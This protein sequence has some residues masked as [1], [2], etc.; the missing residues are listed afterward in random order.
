MSPRLRALIERLRARAGVTA[1]AGAVALTLAGGAVALAPAASAAP[2]TPAAVAVTAARASAAVTGVSSSGTIWLGMQAVTVTLRVASKYSGTPRACVHN[3]GPHAI[4]VAVLQVNG[5]TDEGRL[6]RAGGSQCLHRGWVTVAGATATARFGVTDQVNG[7]P[8]SATLRVGGGYAPVRPTSIVAAVQLAAGRLAADG[9]L[10]PLTRAR[11]D[12]VLNHGPAST[13]AR[14][15]RA[16]GVGADGITGPVTR[17][18]WMQLVN[19]AYGR[20]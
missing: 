10:G 8:G 4:K 18:A 1:T 13:V 12:S 5:V 9:D 16:L 2:A 14:V 6:L 3:S 20:Y 7:V 17:D 15:Q 19:A 11:V